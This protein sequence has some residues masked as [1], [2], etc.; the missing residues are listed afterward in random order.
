MC[1]VPPLL[2]AA[3]SCH[4]EGSRYA[5]SASLSCPLS[6]CEDWRRT[7][8]TLTL[9]LR[10]L[11]CASRDGLASRCS[12]GRGL[13][14]WHRFRVMRTDASEFSCDQAHRTSSGS[15][16]PAWLRAAPE[17][18]PEPP[19]A[20]RERSTASAATLAP[21]S[22]RSVSRPRL[23]GPRTGLDSWSSTLSGSECTRLGASTVTT[24]RCQSVHVRVPRDDSVSWL[25]CP[26]GLRNRKATGR[27]RRRAGAE[28][29]GQFA[30]IS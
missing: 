3:E 23:R 26:S 1:F 30:R 16:A 29:S 12:H 6:P 19:T 10:L 20:N 2:D 27:D 15:P 7:L 25:V 22:P 4:Y 17:P 18:R 24:L 5:S 8:V 14:G 21:F 13:A 11:V 9:F 28:T